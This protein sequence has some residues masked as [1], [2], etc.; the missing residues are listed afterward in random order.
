MELRG[1]VHFSFGAS[2]DADGVDPTLDRSKLTSIPP[3]PP[4]ECPTAGSKGSPF[5]SPEYLLQN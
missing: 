4:I 1:A 5:S 3:L 2:F